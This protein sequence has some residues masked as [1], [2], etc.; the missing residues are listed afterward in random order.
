MPSTSL[1]KWRASFC[2]LGFAAVAFGAFGAHALR[3]KVTPQ[4]LENWK[5]AT[6][7]LLAHTLAGLVSLTNCRKK[8]APSFFLV[9]C[10]LFPF[11][12][13]AL[14]LSGIRG[15]GAVTPLGGLCFLAGWVLF[16][17]DSLRSE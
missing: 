16:A 17:R 15:L 12:L 4:D 3:D 5:T 9:G 13:Y 11:S 8:H 6:L 7:Y 14:V 2:A 10:L 1:G